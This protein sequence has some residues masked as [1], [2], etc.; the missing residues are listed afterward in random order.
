MEFGLVELLLEVCVLL[1]DAL[2]LTQVPL[3]LRDLAAQQLD[4]ACLLLQQDVQ[5]GEVVFDVAAYLVGL[6][7]QVHLLLGKLDSLVDLHL[8]LFDQFLLL[9]QDQLDVFVVLFAQQLDLLLRLSSHEVVRV[10]CF[11]IVAMRQAVK[12]AWNAADVG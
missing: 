3:D 10:H 8:M 4:R 6:V 2:G 1:L 9:L 7:A 11:P 12:A 5:A